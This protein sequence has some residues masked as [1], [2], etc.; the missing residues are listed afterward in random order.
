M[1]VHKRGKFIAT[2]NKTK[3]T[4]G[5][6]ERGM[7]H[8]LMGAEFLFEMRKRFWRWRVGTVAREYGSTQCH[9]IA[10]LKRTTVYLKKYLKRTTA[11]MLCIFYHHSESA[12][13][14]PAAYPSC[15]PIPTL[16]VVGASHLLLQL[17]S[18]TWLQVGGPLTKARLLSA[19]LPQMLPAPVQHSPPQE[20][21]LSPGLYQEA[22]ACLHWCSG[23][24]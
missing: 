22:L 11:M 21:R 9:Q 19:S 15:S 3:V 7:G 16:W 4:R 10:Y 1:G 14:R 6:E 18:R 20:E 2:E 23:L 5:W 8:C 24:F 13:I 17:S 12:Q